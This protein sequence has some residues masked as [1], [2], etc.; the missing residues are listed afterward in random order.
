MKTPRV[1]GKV[2]GIARAASSG[3]SWGVI[4]LPVNDIT[5]AYTLAAS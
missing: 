2:G 4:N 5:P 3:V 1:V